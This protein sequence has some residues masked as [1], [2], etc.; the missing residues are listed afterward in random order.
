MGF[1]L[2]SFLPPK[3]R[4]SNI[5]FVFSSL[6]NPTNCSLQYGIKTSFRSIQV[7]RYSL[8]L[9]LTGEEIQVVGQLDGGLERERRV[10]VGPR[11]SKSE[12]DGQKRRVKGEI[13]FRLHYCICITFCNVFMSH[14]LLLGGSHVSLGLDHFVHKLSKPNG[15]V[16]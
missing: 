2:W 4:K 3:C 11:L 13:A 9:E 1:K 5:C 6:T 10:T 14:F 16:I 8:L 7:A 12:K 15:V